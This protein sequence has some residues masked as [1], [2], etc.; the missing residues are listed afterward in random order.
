MKVEIHEVLQRVVAEVLE[1]LAFMFAEPADRKALPRAVTDALAASIQF[2]GER[3]GSMVLAVTSAQCA[4]LAAN[5]LGVEPQDDMVMQH[6][7]DALAELL[8]VAC[9][10]MLTEV[11]GTE[12]VFDMLVPAIT[13]LDGA[14]WDALLD[15]P[16][17]VGF[18]VDDRPV[19][20]QF[21]MHQHRA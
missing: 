1:R 5:V 20:A 18:L 11:A 14:A 2:S 9:G 13:A 19:L 6:R 7:D 8:N 21:M 3:D 16:D 10:H 17:T 12:P 4:E 15:A